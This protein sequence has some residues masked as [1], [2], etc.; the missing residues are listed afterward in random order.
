MARK[1]SSGKRRNLQSDKA[2]RNRENIDILFKMK[3]PDLKIDMEDDPW[4]GWYFYAVLLGILMVI[5]LLWE[6]G[7]RDAAV[8]PNERICS[9]YAAAPIEWR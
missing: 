9:V 3:M 2:K 6:M 4:E 1:R 7:C 8:P 5:I